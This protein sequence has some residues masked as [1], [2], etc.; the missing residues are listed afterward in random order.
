MSGD[1]YLKL[2]DKET[3]LHDRLYTEAWALI[4]DE[5]EL[6]G[7]SP[8]NEP[9]RRKLKKAISLFEQTLKLNPRN[10]SC[11]WALGKIHQR[12]NDD[13]T[14]LGWFSEAHKVEPD[15]PDILRE[16]ALCAMKLGNGR[17]AV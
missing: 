8:L 17:V 15:N 7:R 16:A 6:H 4:Q 13:S 14:A 1:T 5:I 12:L 9:D 11:M 10:W 3:K 2:T